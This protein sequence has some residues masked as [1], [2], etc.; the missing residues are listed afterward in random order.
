MTANSREESFC[1]N[2]TFAV[3]KRFGSQDALENLVKNAL[4]VKTAQTAQSMCTFTS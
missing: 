4:F 1:N 3:K 2:I